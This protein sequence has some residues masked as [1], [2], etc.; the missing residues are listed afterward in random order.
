[1]A[2]S[3]VKT[4]Q[5]VLKGFLERMGNPFLFS[6]MAAYFVIHFE[7]FLYLL[8]SDSKGDVRI[9]LFF[10]KLGLEPE[11]V[12]Y[13]ATL[14]YLSGPL[15]IA[16]LYCIVWP[17]ITD[18]LKVFPHIASNWS[19]SLM[20]RTYKSNFLSPESAEELQN[21]LNDLEKKLSEERSRLRTVETD[22]EEARKELKDAKTKL[23]SQEDKIKSLSHTESLLNAEVSNLSEE[24]DILK[25]QYEATIGQM[26]EEVK[27]ANSKIKQAEVLKE[28]WLAAVD[29]MKSQTQRNNEIQNANKEFL[30]SWIS[31]I[32]KQTEGAKKLNDD[33]SKHMKNK[34]LEVLTELDNT[35]TKY[36]QSIARYSPKEDFK[37]VQKLIDEMKKVSDVENPDRSIGMAKTIIS[38]KP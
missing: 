2:T 14:V 27:Q 30:E 32:N 16:A 10:E 20:A 5:D 9:T 18:L 6:F 8:M 11:I 21:E 13:W 15:S 29:F 33:R 17:F 34:L 28:N 4:V 36:S 12:G 26:T 1:M 7:A 38:D 22:Y 31:S 37:A 23:T 25:T 3:A 24:V 35:V 19:T